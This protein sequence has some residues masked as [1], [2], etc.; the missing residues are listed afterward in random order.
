MFRCQILEQRLARHEMQAIETF[1]ER[2]SG[3]WLGIPNS[4]IRLP[5]LKRTFEYILALEN[6]WLEDEF[7]VEMLVSGMLLY[8]TVLILEGEHWPCASPSAF[9]GTYVFDKITSDRLLVKH[10]P[11]DWGYAKAKHLYMKGGWRPPWFPDTPILGWGFST[12]KCDGGIS[13]GSY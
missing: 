7:P 3:A 12:M 8:D 13:H 6:Q 9:K 11:N 10:T 5:S 1:Q 4:R 2:M